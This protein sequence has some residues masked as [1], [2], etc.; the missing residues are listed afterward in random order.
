MA[1][2]AVKKQERDV[3][4]TSGVVRLMEVTS[5]LTVT[6]LAMR[7]KKMKEMAQLVASSRSLQSAAAHALA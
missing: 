5:M 3:G 7:W 1:V 2:K 4:C 6:L